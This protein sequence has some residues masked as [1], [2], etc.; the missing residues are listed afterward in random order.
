MAISDDDGVRSLASTKVL[1]LTST[2]P[3]FT[4]DMQPSFVLDQAH[5]WKAERPQD[6]VT[7]VAAVPLFPARDMAKTGLSGDFAEY[8]EPTDYGTVDRAVSDR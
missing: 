1:F 6:R 2:L 4:G 5:A 7:I 8:Q 3:R